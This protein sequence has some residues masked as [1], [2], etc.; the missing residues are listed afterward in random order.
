M[1]LDKLDYWHGRSRLC[2]RDTSA[3]QGPFFRLPF[4]C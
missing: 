2:H 3:D 4:R 1:D